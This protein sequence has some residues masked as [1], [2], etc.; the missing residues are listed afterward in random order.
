MREAQTTLKIGFLRHAL[1][2][3]PTRSARFLV[4]TGMAIVVLFIFLTLAPFVSPYDPTETVGPPYFPPG[5]QFLMGTDNHGRDVLSRMIWGTRIALSIA[6]FSTV[7]SA[8]I[9][10]PVGLFSGYFGGKTDRILSL[11]MDSIYA[12]PGIILAIAVTT[13]LGRGIMNVALAIA[14]VY[15]PTYFRV[16]RSDVLSTK[17]K[18]YVEAAR[19]LGASSY[20]ILSRYILFNV[21]PSA[22]V[23]FS[24]NIADAILTE[25][26]L[27]YLAM[28]P[29]EPPTPDWG[30]DLWTGQKFLLAGAWWLI[31]FPGLMIVLV[32]LGFS[33]LGDGLDEILNPKLR[34]R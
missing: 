20:T 16:V 19:A 30:Y 15:V 21:I 5:L 31:T 14:V 32:A 25:A 2:K 13:M 6:L 8:T 3:L 34:E 1:E 24:L 23:I 12:F 26:G 7:L 29:V 18:L 17:E 22:S 10:I 9:G 11:A 27:S 4:I 28:G 33:M